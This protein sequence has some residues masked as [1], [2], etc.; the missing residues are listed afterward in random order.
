MNDLN[1]STSKVDNNSVA[2]NPGKQDWD[3]YSSGLLKVS[4]SKPLMITIPSDTVQVIII[5]VCYTFCQDW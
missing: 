2:S 3:D 5:F 4:L 1:P